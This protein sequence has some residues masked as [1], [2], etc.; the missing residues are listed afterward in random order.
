[1]FTRHQATMTMTTMVLLR[2]AGMLTCFYF[3]KVHFVLHKCFKQ[4]ENTILLHVGTVTFTLA[5]TQL[6]LAHFP[7][8]YILKASVCTLLMENQIK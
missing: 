2:D 4:T 7:E 5:V 1:M 6:P 8:Q 3:N